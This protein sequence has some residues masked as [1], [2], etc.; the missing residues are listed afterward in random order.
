[1]VR[2]FDA[3]ACP[4]AN[5]D[6]SQTL[7]GPPSFARLRQKENG[8]PAAYRVRVSRLRH[9]ERPPAGQIKDFSSVFVLFGAASMGQDCGE[10]LPT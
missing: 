5:K 4:R 10:A 2:I 9:G 8:A 7:S 6:L 3:T 1:M